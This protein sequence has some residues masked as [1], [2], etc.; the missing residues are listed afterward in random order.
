MP[1]TIANSIAAGAGRM[2]SF[3]GPRGMRVIARFN[4]RATNPAAMGLASRL[5]Y[6]AIIEHRGRRS[7]K[8]YQTPVMAF[9]E[10]GGLSVVLNYGMESDW[11][12]N[13]QAAGSAE[14]VHRGQRYRLTDPRVIPI[15]S[16]DLP[17]AVRV[18]HTPAGSAFHGT[19]VAG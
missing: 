6:M 2:S 8:S 9:V 19:L 7:G 1:G 11:V 16:L 3:L 10:A 5:P 12:L 14:V 13:V 17:A 15:D 4:K 18:V